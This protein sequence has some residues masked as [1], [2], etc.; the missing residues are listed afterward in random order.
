MVNPVETRIK[1][2]IYYHK[3]GL[4][5]EIIISGK[6]TFKEKEGIN[7]LRVALV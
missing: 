7:T 3:N 1:K 2:G 4:V 5:K 6:I